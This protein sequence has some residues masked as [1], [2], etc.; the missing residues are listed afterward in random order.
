[1]LSHVTWALEVSGLCKSYQGNFLALDHVNFTVAPGDFFAL[2]GPNGAGKST[3]IGIIS[4]L[5]R[6][7]QG[8]VKIMGFDIDENFP[9]GRSLLGIVPQ[10]FNINQFQKTL[11]VVAMQAGFYGLPHRTAV[12]Q[13]EEALH[14][15]GLWEKRNQRVGRLSGGMK[16]RL[17][18][19]RALAHR[20]SLLILDEPTAGV[21][22]EIRMKIW[23]LMWDLNKNGITIILTTHYLEEAEKLC[24]NIAILNRGSI[25]EH[26]SMQNLLRKLETEYLLLHTAQKLKTAPTLNMADIQLRS[27]T[28]LEVKIQ[29]GTPLNQVFSGLA[30]QGIE[31]LSVRNET[32]RLERIFLS[33]VQRESA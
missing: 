13:A 8:T 12:K 23:D 21:D 3:L 16:R 2:L 5:V 1:M 18:I 22:L 14:S 24:R 33:L 17:M 27:E 32:T 7:S 26:T 30:L 31:I 25:L 11:D 9:K 20:P 19:A 15:V 10:E 29:K 6:K 28:E 4:S